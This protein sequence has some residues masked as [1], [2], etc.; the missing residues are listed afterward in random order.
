[1]A[2]E[3]GTMKVVL[4]SK[5]PARLATL[6]AA[7]LEP[8]VQVS[9][10]DEDA[11]LRALNAPDIH[12]ARDQ[13]LALAEAKASTVAAR[14]GHQPAIVI[15]CDSMFEMDGEV[16]GKP[17][18]AAD[19]LRRLKAMSGRSGLLHTG[20]AVHRL[21]TGEIALE[22]AQ[23][24]VHIGQ[25]TDDEIT[26]YIKTGE[27]LAV[28]GSFTIDG[29]GGWFVDGL[30]GDHTNVIGISLPL[31]RRMLKGLGIPILDLITTSSAGL[32]S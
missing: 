15:G 27:P 8:E 6:R 29:I 10:V 4:A 24:T 30:N 16:R 13:V 26:G 22:A 2:S 31:L 1:M 11:I 9:D 18:D 12:S 20:H 28:A 17:V 32:T 7:G 19:A 23:T 14:L 25:L 21:D 3:H 5:S